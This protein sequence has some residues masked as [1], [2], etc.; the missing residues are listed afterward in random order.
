MNDRFCLKIQIVPDGSRLRYEQ[1]VSGSTFDMILLPVLRTVPAVLV[2]MDR[3]PGDKRVNIQ[4]SEVAQ[5]IRQWRQ[6]AID[7]L[8]VDHR[9]ATQD[10]KLPSG[11]VL[12]RSSNLLLLVKAFQQWQKGEIVLADDDALALKVWIG[13][14]VPFGTAAVESIKDM[15]VLNNLEDI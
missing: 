1:S 9:K 3:Y 5:T 11:I 7:V 15:K 10:I 6:Q 14:R 2:T 12:S 4:R 8:L 13:D